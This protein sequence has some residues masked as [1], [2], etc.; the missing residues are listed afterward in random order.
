M[1]NLCI[2]HRNNIT[3]K[4]NASFITT[5]RTHTH[6]HTGMLRQASFTENIIIS[7]VVIEQRIKQTQEG[8][9]V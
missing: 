7:E 5:L 9:K 6:T 8:K 3:F 1:E 4:T 2:L